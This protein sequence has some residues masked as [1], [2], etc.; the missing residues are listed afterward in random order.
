[1]IKHRLILFFLYLCN[2]FTAQYLIAFGRWEKADY[3][4]LPIIAIV[5]YLAGYTV[6]HFE[7]RINFNAF[8]FLIIS[9][10]I[11]LI[12]AL[13]VRGYII[14]WVIEVCI[15]L[16]AFF[17]GFS[18]ALIRLRKKIIFLLSLVIYTCLVSFIINPRIVYN[19]M[20]ALNSKKELYGTPVSFKYIDKNGFSYTNKTFKNKVV[21]VEYWFVGCS[22]C[23]LKMRELKKLAEHYKDN[24]DFAIVTVDAGEID[25]F[26]NFKKEVGLLPSTM[27]NTYD[28]A[29]QTAT[30][31]KVSGYPTEFLIDR[32]GMIRDQFVGYGND[33]KLV[34]LNKTIKK[35]DA[36]LNE[37]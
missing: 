4:K 25:S 19:K 10:G 7:K 29:S 6:Q 31:L 15:A 5:F 21:L 12:P 8:L 36:L 37:K 17:I 30:F 9:L 11:G 2:G 26:E 24:K 27:I 14:N 23:Y 33:L 1:M 35:I 32:N 34:Y 16:P 22:P 20:I 28:S 18:M 13:D 3:I